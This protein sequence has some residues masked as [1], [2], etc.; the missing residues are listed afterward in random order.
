MIRAFD[1]MV[2][3]AARQND[4]QVIQSI[5]IIEIKDRFN[6]WHSSC[7]SAFK[8]PEQ[9]ILKKHCK[10]L[11]LFF[12]LGQSVIASDLSGRIGLRW[13]G[14]QNDSPDGYGINTPGLFLRLGLNDILSTNSDFN[15]YL[16]SERDRYYNEISNVRVYNLALGVHPFSERVR[17][18]FGRLNSRF[19][20]A[21][22]MLDGASMTLSATK[23]LSFGM[24]NGNTP[25][26]SSFKTNEQIQRYG[27]FSSL[28]I[29]RIYSGGASFV[30]QKYIGKLDRQ[31]LL[32]NNLFTPVSWLSFY[33]FAELDLKKM[34]AAETIETAPQLTNFFARLQIRPGYRFSADLTVDTRKDV[35][36]LQTNRSLPD[37]LFEANV[38]KRYS[39]G[40][41]WRPMVPWLFTARYKTGH[42]S[43]YSQAQKYYYLAI[44]NY[45]LFKSR[46]FAELS[47]VSNTSSYLHSTNHYLMLQYPIGRSLRLTADWMTNTLQYAYNSSVYHENILGLGTLFYLNKRISIHG[48]LSW[49]ATEQYRESR[50]YFEFSYRFLKD[51][52]KQ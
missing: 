39:L 22:G 17:L 48:H 26:L 52:K 29:N 11:V 30:T 21:Y 23:H 49:L 51:R 33:Q 8:N 7:V 6:S 31:F 12:L 34:S 46:T 9:K 35:V 20:G 3:L 4:L 28:K 25:E 24:F 14:M 15:I 45:N 38:D 41:R 50:L 37:S 44:S 40:I 16:R 2:V 1:H 36:Y 13:Y 42:S 18:D 32:F 43:N 19:L 10:T 5:V 27:I 47:F